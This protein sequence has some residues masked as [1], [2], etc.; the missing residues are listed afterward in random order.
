MTPLGSTFAGLTVLAGL[1][2]LPAMAAAET[3]AEM[4]PVT[5]RIA[6]LYGPESWFT[7]PM[8]AF[9]ERTGG[10]VAFEYYYAGS[11]V[12]AKDLASDLGSGLFEFG[13]VLGAYD[14]VRFPVDQWQGSLALPLDPDPVRETIL[15]ALAT[16]EWTA[17]LQAHR[18][19]LL[20]ADIY[21]LMPSLPVTGPFGT[22]CRED[23]ST[24]GSLQGKRIRVAGDTWT[25]EAQNLGMTPVTLP[26]I[27]VYQAFQ[28]G[29]IDCWMGGHGDA[30]ALGLWDHGK[31]G[32]A[33]AKARWQQAAKD[34]L[35][36]AEDY[37]SWAEFAQ[38][39]AGALPDAAP[40]T[41][42]SAQ[43]I[44]KLRTME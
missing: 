24:L 15:T 7:W 26:I 33:E 28:S 20:K 19:E 25:K 18:N 30:G 42:A 32:L 37:A 44:A 8:A 11:L 31:A 41:H 2:G 40:L 38:K 23:N 17:G 16:L 14:P 35:G 12:P 6:T 22:L 43:I 3:L 10:K 39:T 27:E 21:P 13:F 34:R 5:P 29:V 1:A 36:F 9:T 4:K